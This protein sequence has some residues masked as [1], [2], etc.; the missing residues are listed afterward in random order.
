VKNVLKLQMLSYALKLMTKHNNK[1]I[2]FTTNP[3]KSY[4]VFYKTIKRT[5]LTNIGLWY[6]HLLKHGQDSD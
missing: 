1:V 4:I 5:S 6:M 3:L 2:N